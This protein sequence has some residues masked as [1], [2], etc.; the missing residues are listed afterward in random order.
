[1]QTEREFL[2]STLEF[3]GLPK[4]YMGG[5]GHFPMWGK[6]SQAEKLAA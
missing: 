4:G 5:A 6:E 3:F 2:L 1:V